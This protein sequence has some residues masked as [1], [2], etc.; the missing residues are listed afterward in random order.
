[1]SPLI[2]TTS[3]S[4]AVAIAVAVVS[5]VVILTLVASAVSLR[6]SARE[7]RILADELNEHAAIVLR[8][9]ERTVDLARG[10]LARVDDLIG[11]AEAIT[12]TVG[13]ASRLAHAAV[14]TPVIK[15]MA[16]AAG[17]RRA[18]RRM[19]RASSANRREPLPRDRRE[20]LPRDRRALPAAPRTAAR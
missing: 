15:V 1:L 4:G 16:L 18:G 13:S 2:A 3:G 9:V 10:E 7:L 14:A 5:T 17:T 12:E 11:S 20:P 19:R 8:E 6:R